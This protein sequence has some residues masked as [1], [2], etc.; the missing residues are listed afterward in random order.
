MSYYNGQVVYDIDRKTPVVVGD[1]S[2]SLFAWKVSGRTTHFIEATDRA[3]RKTREYQ[4]AMPKTVTEALELLD[5]GLI[6]PTPCPPSH[7]WKCRNWKSN[8]VAFKECSEWQ[9]HNVEEP[10]K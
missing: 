10:K 6:F 1:D 5:K 8:C 2:G 4:L 9:T 3:T 7:C